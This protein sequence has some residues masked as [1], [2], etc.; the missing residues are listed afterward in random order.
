M[1]VITTITTNQHVQI[2]RL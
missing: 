2:M 1:P